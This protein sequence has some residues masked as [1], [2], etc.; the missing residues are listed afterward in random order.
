MSYLYC[1]IVVKTCP[2]LT[3][4]KDGH[5]KCYHPDFGTEYENNEEKLPVDTICEFECKNGKMLTGSRQRSCI[6]LAQWDGLRTICKRN[7]INKTFCGIKNHSV[8]LI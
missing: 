5:M 3:A 2:H 7:Y 4:P 6:P 1:L 8:F